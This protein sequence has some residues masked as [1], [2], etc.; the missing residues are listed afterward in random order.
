MY[1]NTDNYSVFAGVWFIL[2]ISSSINIDNSGAKFTYDASMIVCLIIA[3]YSTL[4]H[5]S[6][7]AYESPVPK[8]FTQSHAEII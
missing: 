6:V 7:N 3:V 2:L 8:D 4:C 5:V 1:L